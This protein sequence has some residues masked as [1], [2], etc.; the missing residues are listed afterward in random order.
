V[1]KIKGDVC[2]FAGISQPIV[3]AAG[4][5]PNGHLWPESL[6]VVVENVEIV[7]HITVKQ[8]FSVFVHDTDVHRTGMKVDATVI[9]LIQ[10]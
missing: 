9:L 4:F 5:D 6:D 7:W 3:V 2:F 10:L 8:N 1:A